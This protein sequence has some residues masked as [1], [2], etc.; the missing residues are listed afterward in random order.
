MK[1][2]KINN[3]LNFKLKESIRNIRKK[4]LNKNI[5]NKNKITLMIFLLKLLE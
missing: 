2:I 5:K 4:I 1:N 3:N